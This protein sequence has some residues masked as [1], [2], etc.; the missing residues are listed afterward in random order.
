MKREMK[1]LF[2][3]GYTRDRLDAIGHAVREAVC[4]EFKG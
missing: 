3:E 2:T 1:T 4:V